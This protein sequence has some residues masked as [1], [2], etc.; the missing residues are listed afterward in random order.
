[1]NARDLTSAL[2]D[3]HNLLDAAGANRPAN[4]VRDLVALVQGREEA[5]LETLL[6]EMRRAFSLVDVLG[7]ALKAAGPDESAFQAAFRS[8]KSANL[9]KADLLA[10]ARA[11]AGA[12]DSSMS[13]DK[14]LKA[15]ST[16]FYVLAYE[17]DSRILAKQA[18]PV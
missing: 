4:E 5:E 7:A 10:V 18:T 6:A 13:K 2:Q 12:V 17:R 9:S 16:H 14:I 15:I 3:I 11:Y 8:L 1:M